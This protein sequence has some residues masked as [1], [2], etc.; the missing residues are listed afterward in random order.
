MWVSLQGKVLWFLVSLQDMVQL[1]ILDLD[2]C[3]THIC[4]DAFTTHLLD[5][6]VWDTLCSLFVPLALIQFPAANFLF[7]S[8]LLDRYF[9]IMSSDDIPALVKAVL[10]NP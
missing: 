4:K 2:K 1:C 7:P 6:C 9:Q 8:C 10:M 5:A 3:V